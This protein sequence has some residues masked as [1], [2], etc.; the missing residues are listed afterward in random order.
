MSYIVCIKPG[1]AR[2]ADFFNY[3]S[4]EK[5]RLS[6]EWPD[7]FG[8]SEAVNAGIAPDDYGWYIEAM[9][10][11]VI[12]RTHS[13]NTGKNK[14]NIEME[15]ISAETI[16]VIEAISRTTNTQGHAHINAAY[17]LTEKG[18]RIPVSKAH[19]PTPFEVN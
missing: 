11:A 18:D 14:Y 3:L 2:C 12:T 13:D 9:Q 1:T 4:A 10:N 8:L 15:E 6:R 16:A 17:Y 19:T 5:N 7:N